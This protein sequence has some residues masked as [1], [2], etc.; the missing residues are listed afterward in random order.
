MRRPTVGRGREAGVTPNLL[1]DHLEKIASTPVLLCEPSPPLE[2]MNNQL[3]L[4][5]LKCAVSSNILSQP[6]ELQCGTLV[7]TKCLCEWTAASGAVNCPC[8]SEGGPLVSSHVRPAPGVILLLLSNVLVHCTDCSRDVKAGDYHHLHLS[9]LPLLQGDLETAQHSQEVLQQVATYV[10]LVHGEENPLAVDLL[11]QS[12]A[13]KEICE[14]NCMQV[15][16]V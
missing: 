16:S 15:S 6:L 3:M 2:S 8:C 10:A 9:R 12:A 11:K 1:T 5:E 14:G 13:K 4:K 7:C